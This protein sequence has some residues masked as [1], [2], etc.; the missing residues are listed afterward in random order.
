[1]AVVA[2]RRFIGEFN[3]QLLRSHIFTTQALAAEIHSA[4]PRGSFKTHGVKLA[5]LKEIETF[6]SCF[7]KQIFFRILG[8]NVSE[9]N[10]LHLE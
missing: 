1:M 4:I 6:I 9:V 2:Q 3:F 5:L 10:T 8:F 7:S